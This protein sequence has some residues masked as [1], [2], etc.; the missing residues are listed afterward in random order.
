MKGRQISSRQLDCGDIRLGVESRDFSKSCV[1][2]T[3]ARRGA[4][5]ARL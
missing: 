5:A 3:Y 2:F 4:R 1:A